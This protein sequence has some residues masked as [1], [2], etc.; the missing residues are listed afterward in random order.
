MT[1]IM[2][3][4]IASAY[5]M[6]TYLLSKNKT[7][8][9]SR[10]ISALDFCQIFLNECAKENVRGDVAF[11]QA[12]KETGNFNYGGDVNYTQNNFAGIGAT[13]N[14]NPGNIFESIEI[15]VLAQAQHLKSYACKDEL[16]EP[17]VDP[18]RTAWFMDT[19]GGS[20]PDVETLGGSWAVPGYN[21]AKYK[22]LKEANDAKDSYG[23]QI[24]TILNHI[25]EVVDKK[26]DIPLGYKVAID[27]GHG[28]NTA[29]K[30]SPDGY[31]EHWINVKCAN[32]F[33]VAM[34]RCG[35]NTL[36]VAWD[37]TDATDDE[38]VALATRQSQIKNAKCDISVSWHANASGSGSTFNTAKGL[39]TL[40]HNDSSK[41]GDSK[42]L[43]NKVHAQLIKGTS[44]TNR[45]V[46]GQSLAMC[47]CPAMNTKASILIEIG[48]MT[49]EY[50]I[51][52]MKTDAFCLE[53]A[54]EAA[55]GVC[56]YLGVK[57][58]ESTVCK[59]TKGWNK[60]SKGWWFSPDGMTY[61]A[62]SFRNINGHRYF[63]DE[64]GYITTGWKQIDGKWYFFEN[65]AGHDFEG[66]LY[67]TDSNGVQTIGSF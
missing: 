2:G 23:Y 28:S 46:K 20:S 15:G 17:N 13:G 56:E 31:R 51:G 65:T 16:N 11:A 38:D 4:A 25:L 21:T 32:Y 30:R 67:V 18:R 44:Q 66:A 7:P 45:G 53:C 27:A 36:K 49:N 43:A 5:Q 24:I 35:I 22:S 48:F 6:S 8:K 54:E 61:Y 52:L 63:F 57:Y 50:E 39:E 3:Q 59:Y 9:F 34:K 10:N 60:D 41:V 64:S 29:G 1:K 47:N 33:D 26:E 42:N 40:I 12:C 55:K 62:N 19:K 14:K 58:V 37:D